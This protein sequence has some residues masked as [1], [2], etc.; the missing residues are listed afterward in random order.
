[1]RKG[2]QKRPH[3]AHKNLSPNCTPETVLHY[4]FKTLLCQK[5]QD[6]IDHKLRLEI[7]WGYDPCEGHHTGNLLRKAVQVKSECKLGLYQPDISLLDQN[8]RPIAV[9]EVIVTHAPEQATVNY[10]KLNEITLVTYVLESDEDIYP[11]LR[12]TFKQR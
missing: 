5:I 2:S 1:M 4:S 7:H 10:Y 6:C 8:G 11:R 3:F 9:I 12:R